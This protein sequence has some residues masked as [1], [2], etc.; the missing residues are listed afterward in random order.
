MNWK[1]RNFEYRCWV[2]ALILG[3]LVVTGSVLAAD[4]P[5]TMEGVGK[6]RKIRPIL[7]SEPAGKHQGR[8]YWI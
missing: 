7:C 2:P 4:A 3:W 5:K 1:K 8:G 6:R